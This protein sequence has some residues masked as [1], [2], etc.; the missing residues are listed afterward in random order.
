MALKTRMMRISNGE[1]AT[2]NECDRQ[3]G[4]QTNVVATAYRGLACGASRDNNRLLAG[5]G[6]QRRRQNITV[7]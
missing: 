3:S 1:K 5:K 2:V 4:G 6:E 7:T